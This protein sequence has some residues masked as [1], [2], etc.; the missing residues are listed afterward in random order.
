M[1][2]KRILVIDDDKA[3]CDLLGEIF[4][5]QGWQ[6][7]TAQTPDAARALADTRQFDL[8]VSD[9]NLE[10]DTNGIDLLR[11]FR[12][13]IPVILITAFGSLEASIEARR[14]GAWDL[15]SKPFNFED[16][17][18]AAERAMRSRSEAYTDNSKPS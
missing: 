14:E 17:I 13:K 9:I 5:D 15:I 4:E 2:K 1:E 3:S 6:V 7:E 11:G 18:T 16:V 10:A 12:E 8:V